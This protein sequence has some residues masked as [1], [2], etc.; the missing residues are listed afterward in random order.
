MFYNLN[1]ST[2][3]YS[4]ARTG[5]TPGSINQRRRPFFHED[6][7]SSS[8]HRSALIMKTTFGRSARPYVCLYC[9]QHL[10]RTKRRTFASNY[11]Q[12]QS[13]YDVVTIGGGPVGLALLAAL[14]LC[15]HALLDKVNLTCVESSPV[16]SHLKVALIEA[17][18][19][20]KARN[21]KHPPEEY[22]NRASSLTPSSVSFLEESG[23]WKHVDQSR[24][25]PYD[26]M[27]VWDGGNDSSIQFDHKAEARKYNAP[28][29]IVATM[30]ENANLTKGL[31]SRIS[32]LDAESSLLTNTSVSSIEHGA[33][34]PEG[35]NLCTWPMVNASSP[36]NA[37]SSSLAAR[38]LVGADGFNSPVR[39]FAWVSSAGWDYNRHGVVA[40]LS[41]E[42]KEDS[43]DTF[44]ND[45]YTVSGV[46]YQRFLP[47]L[48]G[49]IALLPLPNN[50]ASLVWS[51]TPQNAS[52]LKTL[53]P[54]SL[55]ALI[56]AAFHL[57]Q[58]DIKYLFTIPSSESSSP[59]ASIHA[60]EFQ[61]R[62]KHTSRPPLSPRPPL[63][64]AVQ[65]NTLAS[66][67][68]RFRHASTYIGPRVALI[69]DAAHTIHPLA[70]QGLNLGLADA[71]ALASTIEYAVQHGQDL[72]D[73]M[74]LERYNK[75]RWGKNLAMAMGVDGLNS[76][77][78]MGA[79]GDGIVSRVIGRVRGVGMN[80]FG[81]A[82]MEGVRSWVMRQAE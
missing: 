5:L 50:K 79:G 61:W 16:T 34:D 25:Q 64:T 22:S 69:G 81:S 56:N 62:L 13:I 9:Q 78:Q 36:T 29:R 72:G 75:E 70:G 24:T 19:L 40:T 6:Q 77:Y 59:P 27:E 32:E 11:Q 17:Q 1:Q 52:Y 65:P 44:F 4:S 55:S 39:N 74:T 73:M 57:D 26:R 7:Q 60:D 3:T 15:L 20:S 21:W 45:D 30:T 43:F 18:D 67:P 47:D 66:F 8:Y 58:A 82:P 2:P 31:L 51:T 10:L 42:V 12:N 76:V 28:A 63:I 80:V 48:G 33:D 41:T 53:S 68:L 49:P 35:L 54:E 14:S 71:Q 37:T 38:L 46:A 23:A